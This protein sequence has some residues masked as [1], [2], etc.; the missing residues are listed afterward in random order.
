MGVEGSH[1]FHDFEKNRLE[2]NSRLNFRL[3]KGLA[4]NLRSSLELIQ[5]QLS[6]PKGDVSLQDVLLSQTQQATDFESFISLG[7][8]YTFGSVFNN[9]VNTRL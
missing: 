4:L 5:D 1:Y 8:S 7:V 3:V 6:L 9:I 2:F